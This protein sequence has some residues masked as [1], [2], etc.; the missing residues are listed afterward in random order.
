MN[1]RKRNQ[2]E[3]LNPSKNEKKQTTEDLLALIQLFVS[4]NTLTPQDS[5]AIYRIVK[6]LNIQKNTMPTKV[7]RA[8]Q[9]KF[10][11]IQNKYQ[12]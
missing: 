7:L 9:R 5:I 2:Q 6:Q 3:H 11:A 1:E 12:R 8:T 4:K 10:E